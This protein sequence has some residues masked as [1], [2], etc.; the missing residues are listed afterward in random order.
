ML[1]IIFKPRCHLSR[2]KKYCFYSYKSGCGRRVVENSNLRNTWFVK[3]HYRSDTAKRNCS[4]HC[5]FANFLDL[6]TFPGYFTGISRTFCGYFPDILRIFPG[7]FAVISR[8]FPGCFPD[9]F[10]RKNCGRFPDIFRLFPGCFPDI[11]Y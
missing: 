6:R 4:V 9:I 10:L 3:G 8:T 7:H 11:F 1:W 2:S 5:N